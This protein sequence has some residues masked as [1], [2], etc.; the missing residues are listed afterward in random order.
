MHTANFREIEKASN[1]N[2]RTAKAYAADYDLNSR[3]PNQ[4]MIYVA[5]K[6]VKKKPFKFVLLQT[7]SVHITNLNTE[8]NA[9]SSIKKYKDVVEKSAGKMVE[10]A[11][12]I[13]KE[14][15]S[16]EKIFLVDCAQRFDVSR[17]DPFGLKPELAKYNNTI[18]MDLVKNSPAKEKIMIG[19]HILNCNDESFGNPADPRFDCIHVYGRFGSAEYTSSL[20]NILS[21]SMQI[22]KPL[23]PIP[24][25][26]RRTTHEKSS[27]EFESNKKDRKHREAHHH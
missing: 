17:N 8:N 21:K 18:Q 12:A 16:V 14:N 15:S 25:K 5:K 13:L 6:E 27:M 2:V 23:H 11:E 22:T 10:L 20:M 19:N 26:Y 9:E 7:P 1:K 4:N 3:F 24:Q